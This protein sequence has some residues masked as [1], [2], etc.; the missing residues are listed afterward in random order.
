[1][2]QSYCFYQSLD[3]LHTRHQKAVFC[4]DYPRCRRIRGSVC[5][6][7]RLHNDQHSFFCKQSTEGTCLSSRGHTI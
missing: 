6:G 3:R 5:T 7:L 1:M 4:L 2:I